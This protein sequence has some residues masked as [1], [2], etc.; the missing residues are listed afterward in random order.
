MGLVQRSDVE[1]SLPSAGIKTVAHYTKIS[2]LIHFLP[3][4]SKSWSSLY[5]SP[6]QLL[7]DRQELSLGLQTLSQV[8]NHNPRS[9]AAVRNVIANFM[10]QGNDADIDVYQTSFSGVPDDLG[11]W[12]GYG[13]NGMGCS[14]ETNVSELHALADISG[15]VIYEP[16]KQRA[17]AFKVLQSLRSVRNDYD[18]ISRTL[19]AAASFIK[20]VGFQ[21]EHEYRIITFPSKSSKQFRQSGQR[22]VPY[23]DVL[24]GNPI[25]ITKILIGPGWQLA[26]LSRNELA[27]HHVVTGIS[28]LL[29]ASNLL[30]DIIEPSKIPY[31][32]R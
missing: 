8:A 24:S 6:V 12:R 18:R 32:P 11:Q 30:I 1:V 17:F 7:N 26:N 25:G 28:R 19:L 9:S 27:R 21:S 2:N 23:V 13:D 22:I 14:V 20:H 3:P 4:G 10:D 29:E 16:N 31:D 15:W 5:S